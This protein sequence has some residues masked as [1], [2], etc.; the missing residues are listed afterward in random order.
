MGIRFFSDRD[1]PVHLG[2]YPLERLRR[3][4]AMPDLSRVPA[5]APLDFRRPQQPESIVNAMGEYQAMMDAIRDGLV[6]AVKSDIPADPAER[7]DHLKAFGYFSDASMVG[8]GPLPSAAMLAEP[9]RNPDIDRLAPDL[10]TRQ[11][12]TL[13]SGIDMIMADL[14]ESMEAPP[15]TIDGH[16]RAIVFLYEHFRDPRPDEPGSDWIL[17]AQDH[18]ACLRATETAVVIANYIR[19][20][21]FGARAHSAAASDVD[22]GRLAVAAGLASHEDGELVAPWL[23]RRFGLAAV[24]TDMTL[25][26]DAPLAPM[27]SQ[28]RFAMSGPAWWLGKDSAKSALNRDPYAGRNYADGAHPFEKLK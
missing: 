15:T 3:L 4:P 11:T 23:G 10:K 21:G 7:A 13:A 1:R 5:M 12:K 25:A 17:D 20:L 27:A 24:T 14:K 8:T 26:C 19:L 6:N 9:L 16:T 2:P 18:R 28:P 22:L